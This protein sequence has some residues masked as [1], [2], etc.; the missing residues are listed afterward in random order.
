MCG[1][2]VPKSLPQNSPPD[3]LG[4]IFIF[5][6]LIRLNLKERAMDDV[7]K[8]S[9][10]SRHEPRIEEIGEAGEIA[11]VAYI[12][13]QIDPSWDA[14][15][16]PKLAGFP[17]NI[18]YVRGPNREASASR[19]APVCYWF[20]PGTY[21]EDSQRREM[22]YFTR[23]RNGYSIRVVFDKEVGRWE[24]YKFK[25]DALL[26]LAEGS[27]SDRAMIQTT[28]VGAEMDE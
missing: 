19:F 12:P 28:M 22:R 1:T 8:Q 11:F 4:G 6:L 14:K 16:G 26:T 10:G 20:D 15:W 2:Q 27:S 5:R 25:G 9:K 7:T 3:V 17:L 18:A 21:R 24:T 23:P 13:Q